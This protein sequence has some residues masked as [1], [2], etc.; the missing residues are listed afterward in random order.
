MWVEVKQVSCY[1]G[2][3]LVNVLHGTITL[4][5]VGAVIQC[6]NEAVYI[7]CNTI[8]HVTGAYPPRLVVSTPRDRL[9]A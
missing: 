3:D 1:A 4:Q 8:L 6:M 9:V 5:Y 2:N 7:L